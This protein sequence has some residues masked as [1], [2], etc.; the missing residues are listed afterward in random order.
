MN[1]DFFPIFRIKIHKNNFHYEFL[2][3]LK[4][5]KIFQLTFKIFLSKYSLQ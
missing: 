5:L 4:I 1:G 3:S 2:H